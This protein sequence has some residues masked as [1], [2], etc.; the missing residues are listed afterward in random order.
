M[1]NG[2]IASSVGAISGLSWQLAPIRKRPSGLPRALV[3]RW[4]LV[5]ALPRSVG[6]GSV[7][8]LLFFAGTLALSTLARRQL[9]SLA[10]CR[11]SSGT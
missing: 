4:R 3:R 5:P 9:I 6:F 1:R 7:A 11:R 8:D 2:G 10:A